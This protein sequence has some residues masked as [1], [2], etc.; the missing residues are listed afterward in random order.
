MSLRYVVGVFGV[1]DKH[2][3]H[4]VRRPW[5]LAKDN[6]GEDHAQRARFS[7]ISGGGC[8][9]GWVTYLWIGNGNGARVLFVA[10]PSVLYVVH[11]SVIG[12]NVSKVRPIGRP[13]ETLTG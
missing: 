12:L 9:C 13:P 4:G 1:H 2:F 10:K 7:L 11:I 5:L 3:D 6:D 8:E